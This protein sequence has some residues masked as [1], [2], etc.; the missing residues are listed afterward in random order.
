[1]TEAITASTRSNRNNTVVFLTYGGLT[2]LATRLA[3]PQVVLPW[4]YTLIGG[5]LFLFGLLVPSVRFGAM[6][7]QMAAIPIL[8]TMSVRKWLTATACLAIA[9]LLLLLCVAVLELSV[10]SATIAFFVCTLG[11]G[12][13]TGVIQLTSQDVMAKTVG[14]AQIGRLIATMASLGGALT[15]AVSMGFIL[16][17][18][19]PQSENRHLIIIAIAAVIW[20]LAAAAI[21]MVAERPGRSLPKHSLWTEMREGIALYR[22]ERWFR[23]Y[24]TTRMLFLSVGLATPFYSIHAA[25]LYQSSTHTVSLFVFATGVANMLS[26]LVWGRLLNRDPRIVL[27]L[28]AG[29]A[30]VA[31]II[32]LIWNDPKNVDIPHVY[33]IVLA[34]LA[35][36]E[37]GMTQASR[38]YVAVMAPEEERPLYLA[39]NNT[40]VGTVAVGVSGALGVVAHFT[41]IAWALI[42]LIALT[43]CAGASASFLVPHECDHDAGRR[44]NAS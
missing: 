7:S 3:S 28:V 44:S 19:S 9:A 1:M 34:M 14:H 8:R 13:S 20:I 26:G 41:H 5:P 30:A 11:F 16:V 27:M 6:A 40:L 38:T 24:T 39:A 25:S 33:A 23:R 17:H 35:L 2:E 22:T 31:G 42:A 21:S 36:A 15:L 18:P 29:V 37:Q 43:A 32:A 12:I 10:A 4:I